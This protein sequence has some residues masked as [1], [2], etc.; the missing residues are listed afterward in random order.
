[1]RKVI[2]LMMVMAIAGTA[3]AQDMGKSIELP[4]KS[5][6]ARIPNPP[7]EV[8]QGGD[9]IL[10]ATV[11]PGLPYSDEGNTAMFNH[12]YDEQCP[13]SSTSPDVVYSFTPGSDI[14]ITVDL[15]GSD[16]DTKIFIYDDGLNPIACDD[17]F[18]GDGDP[19]GSWTSKIE[20]APLTGGTTYFIVVDGW[21]GEFGNYMINVTDFADCF[22]TCD[23]DAV[24]EGEP[25]MFD[26]YVDLYNTGCNV[27]PP[28]LQTIDWAN[29]PEGE[30]WLCGVSGYHL[31][32]EG[33]FYRDTDWFSVIALGTEMTFTVQAEYTTNA[34][35]AAAPECGTFSELLEVSSCGVPATLS[36]PTTPGEEIW[37]IV[38]PITVWGAVTEYTYTATLIGHVFGVV[39][40]EEVNWGGVKA[41]Y[42]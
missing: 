8:K 6:P 1:M 2:I 25:T 30:A 12:D 32:P 29:T 7:V 13:F 39:P 41:L 28:V 11:I 34:V 35:K 31:S 19:C 16:Y 22:L 23:P 33:F 15:C 26:G 21:G 42:R 9:T 17:D 18:H 38:A 10:S 3:I 27:D 37:L 5:T 20:G 36:F 24:P 40:N 4:V 14:S